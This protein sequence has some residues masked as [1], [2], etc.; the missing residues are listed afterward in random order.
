MDLKFASQRHRD[1]DAKNQ[2]AGARCAGFSRADRAPAHVHRTAKARLA[3]TAQA[4][5][6]DL[7]AGEIAQA[8]HTDK[9]ADE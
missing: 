1:G 7:A 6:G 9:P 4:R 8:A 5:K 2:T 3:H